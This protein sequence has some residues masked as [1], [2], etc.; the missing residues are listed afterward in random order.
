M[1]NI[2]IYI[3]LDN[4]CIGEFES[5]KELELKSEELFG[6]KLMRQNISATLR[7]RYKQYKGFTFRYVDQSTNQENPKTF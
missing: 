2:P 7:G 1:N 6:V 4:K 5:A 3:F